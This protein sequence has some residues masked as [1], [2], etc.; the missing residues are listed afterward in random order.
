ME[1]SPQSLEI[2]GYLVL[3]TSAVIS[4]A[5]GMGAAAISTPFLMIFFK[6]SI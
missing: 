2:I 4:T 1:F 6:L 5:G 3:F